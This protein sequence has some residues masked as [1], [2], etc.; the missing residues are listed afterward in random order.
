MTALRLVVTSISLFL[1]KTNLL[2]QPVRSYCEEGDEGGIFLY[3]GTH[4][5]DIA[6]LL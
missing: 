3:P 5:V 1:R 6:A 4:V 2:G